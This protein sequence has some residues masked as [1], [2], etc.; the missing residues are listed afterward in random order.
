MHYQVNGKIFLNK[1]QAA[2]E[3]ATKGGD[4]HFNLYENVFD[5]VDWGTEPLA[6]WNELLDI[7][8]KQIAAKGKPIVLHFSGG[9]DSY[10]I[11]K[12]FE[13]NNIHI[14]AVYIRKWESETAEQERV[15]DLMFNHFYDKQTK[16]VV[17]SG[18]ELVKN[19]SYLTEDWIW[20]QGTRFQFG[21]I[22]TD[23]ETNDDMANVI[24]TDDFIA[25][26]GFEKPRLHFSESGVFSYQD[27]ANYVRPMNDPR[28]DCFFISPDLPE[29][30][31]K[32]SYMMLNY[33]RSLTPSATAS[34][35]AKY[36]DFHNPNS[37]SWI[38]YSIKA[39]GRFGDLNMSGST[40]IANIQTKLMLP[41]SGKFHGTEFSGRGQ[42]DFMAVKDSAVF[43][44][45][46][47]GIM[48]VVHDPAGKFLMQDT[49]NFYSMKQF[50]SKGYKLNF[51]PLA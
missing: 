22:G 12:V 17:Q 41:T 28:F 51:A 36:N 27:D 48:S 15:F 8:A 42:R 40:H 14:D 9:T 35:L 11:Y 49:T 4:I 33:L 19:K 30:H 3:A 34:A 46:V 45:Y 44:N 23:K 31:V 18:H 37:F 7:R 6:S 16:M 21:Q 26:L 13:R 1:F 39:T 25:I 50:R 20:T 38:D 32:Q 24:G 5:K 2:H 10:T 43:H 47:T 29:L